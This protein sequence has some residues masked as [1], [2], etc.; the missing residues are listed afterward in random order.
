LAA[1]N[2]A[3][4]RSGD[5]GPICVSEDSGETWTSTPHTAHGLWSA[6][7]SSADGSKM[8]AATSGNPSGDDASGIH[9]RQTIPTPSLKI[10]ALGGNTLISW[11]IPSINFTLQEN[12]DLNTTNWTG[13]VTAPLLNFTNLQNQV[14]VPSF[15]GKRFYRLTGQ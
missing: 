8:V 9:L 2:I 5:I 7:A 4:V 1:A 6:V 13:V 12:V 10:K 11:T 3:V 14:T 15:S